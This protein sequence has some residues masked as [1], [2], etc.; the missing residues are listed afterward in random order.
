MCDFGTLEK[1]LVAMISPQIFANER[2]GTPR[3]QRGGVIT[4][5]D[6]RIGERMTVTV[7]QADN[8]KPKL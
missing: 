3:L 5:E 6:R 7:V 1:N 2:I 8:A 4:I